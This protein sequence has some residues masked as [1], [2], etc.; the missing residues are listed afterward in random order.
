MLFSILFVLIQINRS[1]S[2]KMGP[3]GPIIPVIWGP[4]E[5]AFYLDTGSPLTLNVKGG[6]LAPYPVRK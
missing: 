3:R 1:L 2:G 5:G 6:R 4:G